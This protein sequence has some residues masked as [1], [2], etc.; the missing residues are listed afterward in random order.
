M[1]DNK[2][3]STICERQTQSALNKA[4]EFVG[5]L[6]KGE[7]TGMQAVQK[8]REEKEPELR[9]GESVPA[10]SKPAPTPSSNYV[11]KETGIRF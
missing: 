4:L 8:R 11:D 9:G 1:G 2:D 5:L 7:C 10:P 3:T 6:K